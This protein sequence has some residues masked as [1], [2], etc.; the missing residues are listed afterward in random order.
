MG[1]ETGVPE[2]LQA[3]YYVEWEEAD[4]TA[5]A[6]PANMVADGNGTGIGGL[7]LGMDL[8]LATAEIQR[9][10]LGGMLSYSGNL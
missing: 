9:Y 3:A 8:H 6:G 4:K 7:E 2:T 10:I 1:W 5:V